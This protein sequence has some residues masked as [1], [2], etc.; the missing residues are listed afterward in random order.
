MVLGPHL[1]WWLD[2]KWSFK[3]ILPDIFNLVKDLKF[4]V[5]EEFKLQQA[6][7]WLEN[8]RLVNF[9]KLLKNFIGTTEQKDRLVGNRCSRGSF[10]VG[11]TMQ[12]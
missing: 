6:L 2:C 5:A 10:T 12:V 11:S 9:L 1:E 7:K 3:D 4:I 8:S